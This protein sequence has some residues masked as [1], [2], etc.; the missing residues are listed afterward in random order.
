MKRFAAL[1]LVAILII[2]CA[3]KPSGVQV[4]GEKVKLQD[5]LFALIKSS[6][7]D[8]LIQLEMEL[9]D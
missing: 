6:K 1:A 2:S 7:G 3:A 8:L 5:G 4:N 9:Y